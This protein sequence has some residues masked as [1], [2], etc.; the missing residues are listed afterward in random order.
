M[1]TDIRGGEGMSVWGETMR[2]YGHICNT[3]IITKKLGGKEPSIPDKLSI[4]CLPPLSP[5]ETQNIPG[6]GYNTKLVVPAQ[7]S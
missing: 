2:R 1:D 7:R 6:I 5:K 4:L 3:L